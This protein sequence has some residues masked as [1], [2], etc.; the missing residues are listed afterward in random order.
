MK[1]ALKNKNGYINYVIE[2]YSDMVYRIAYT[3]TN[4]KQDSEDIYQEVFLKLAK[5]IPNFKNEEHEKA[6]LIRV[7]INFSK[8]SKKKTSSIFLL[9]GS[10][11]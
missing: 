3:R 4:S 1:S 9:N 2:K 6:W 5:K 10:S 11:E 7:T 8:K